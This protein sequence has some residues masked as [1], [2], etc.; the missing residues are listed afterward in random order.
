MVFLKERL[1]QLLRSI[2]I[3]V[4]SGWL[5]IGPNHA[6]ASLAPNKQEKSKKVQQLIKSNNRF[7]TDD[8]AESIANAHIA[9]S[10]KYGIDLTTGLAISFKES[11]FYPS[12]TSKDGISVGLM[13]VNKRVWKSALQ[14]DMTKLQSIDYNVDVGY[15]ILRIYVDKYGYSTGIR[16]YRGSV[17]DS[18][19]N[20]YFNAIQTLKSKFEKWLVFDPEPAGS[21]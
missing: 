14:L 20:K 17:H 19:N 16:R 6:V 10:E 8:E 4:I 3:I 13:M 18:T 5:I 21:V 7:L 2:G 12:A 1:C 9:A 11:T 15:K